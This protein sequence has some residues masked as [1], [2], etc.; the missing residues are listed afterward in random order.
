MSPL[1]KRMQDAMVLRGMAARTQESY[2]AAVVG[3][4]KHYRRAPEEL[5]SE[6]VERYLLHLIEERKL[7]WSTTN[8]AAAAFSFLYGFT[9]KRDQAR[10]RIA[11]RKTHA[12]QPE[13]LAREEVA[14]I[15]EACASLRQRTLLTTTYAA[16]LRVSEVCALKVAD[17]DSARMMLR[18]EGGKGGRDR[19]TLLSPRLLD[20][21][22]TYWRDAR[23][24][25]WLFPMRDGARPIDSA[26]AQKMYYAAKRVAGVAKQGGIHALRHAF[27]THLLE[28]GVDVHTIQ[29][30]MGHTALATTAR[31]CHLRQTL[32]TTASPFDLLVAPSTTETL[33]GPAAPAQKRLRARSQ[34]RRGARPPA[35]KPAP[36]RP[37]IAATSRPVQ[38]PAGP[39]HP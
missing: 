39:P 3:L 36:K 16:G 13:I 33:A 12:Q 15:L 31:Y 26:Q 17:I 7:S 6:D 21:L 35:V 27:A 37:V 23:P 4:A 1:R 29:R 28:A 30:L 32:A 8:Q 11:R 20:L 19:Y 25:E 34:Q 2:I 38:R 24:G 9:L 18:V 10:F 5:T 22:R 14:R